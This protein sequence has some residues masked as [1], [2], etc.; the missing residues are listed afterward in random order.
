MEKVQWNSIDKKQ[1]GLKYSKN[2]KS[3]TLPRMWNIMM[4]SKDENKWKSP[5]QCMLDDSMCYLNWHDYQSLVEGESHG[6]LLY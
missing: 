5:W 4:A 2:D 1:N 3:S 6:I